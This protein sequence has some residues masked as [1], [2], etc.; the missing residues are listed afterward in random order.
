VCGLNAL[1][2]DAGIVLNGAGFVQVGDTFPSIEPFAIRELGQPLF[3]GNDGVDRSFTMSPSGRYVLFEATL[4]G[5]LEGA[6][7]IDLWQ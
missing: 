2:A 7:L 1:D 6:F 4:A 3:V 5:G